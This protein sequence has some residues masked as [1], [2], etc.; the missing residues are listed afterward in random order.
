MN[1]TLWNTLWQTCKPTQASLLPRTWTFLRWFWFGQPK[2]NTHFLTFNILWQKGR[3]S[4]EAKVLN[5]DCE[6]LVALKHH[7]A[8]TGNFQDRSSLGFRREVKSWQT[9]GWSYFNWGGKGENAYFK[10]FWINVLK[11]AIQACSKQS[12]T[13]QTPAMPE[14]NE[15]QR[16]SQTL[17]SDPALTQ[18]EPLPSWHCFPKHLSKASHPTPFAKPSSTWK[19]TQCSQSRQLRL[20]WKYENTKIKTLSAL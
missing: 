2:T 5:F 9:S 6:Q 3:S 12:F 14:G 18:P 20:P 15:F 8:A 7:Q 16:Q 17:P 13:W 10:Y 19:E 1:N 11:N 4:T